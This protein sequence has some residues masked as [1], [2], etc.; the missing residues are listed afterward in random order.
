[1]TSMIS[2]AIAAPQKPANKPNAKESVSP[3]I[4]AQQKA[5]IMYREP[6]ARLIKPITPNTSVKPADIKN[7]VMPSCKPFRSCSRKRAAVMVF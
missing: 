2:P 6:C 7:N 3:V 1:M 4:Q 5:P